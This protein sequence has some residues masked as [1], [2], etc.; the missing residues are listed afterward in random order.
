MTTDEHKKQLIVIIK[1]LLD[2][3]T[4]TER[5]DLFS[6]YCKWCGCKDPRCQ[7]WNDE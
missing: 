7:C 2:S 4:D 3:L 5:E 1:G 6:E